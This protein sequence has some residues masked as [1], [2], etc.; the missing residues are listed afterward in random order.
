MA[1]IWTTV[2]FDMRSPA[3]GAPTHELYGAAVEMAAFAD[4]I[5]VDAIGLMTTLIVSFVS[6]TFFAL[7]ALSVE[8]E[9][10]FGRMPNDLALDASRPSA[11]DNTSD[12]TPC[13]FCD[14]RL[15]SAKVAP[16]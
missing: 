10:H 3:F 15:V 4:K 2:S 5:G 1:D 11:F 13:Q 8:I 12:T 9:D 7:E 16:L 14:I 6:F